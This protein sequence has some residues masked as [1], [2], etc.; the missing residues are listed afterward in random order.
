MKPIL[1]EIP[2]NI[3]G[4]YHEPFVGGGSIILAILEKKRPRGGVVASDA[5]A[6]LTE[7]W[8]AVRD[9]PEELYREV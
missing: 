9:K 4:T 5:N 2:D 7:F 1:K 3:N 6:T 8:R